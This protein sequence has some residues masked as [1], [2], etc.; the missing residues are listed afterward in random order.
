MAVASVVAPVLDSTVMIEKRSSTADRVAVDPIS[1]QIRVVQP[2]EYQKAAACLA[3]A[4]KEDHVARY[5]IDTPDRAHWSEED[6]FELHKQSMEYLTYAHCLKGLVT[7]VGPDYDAVALWLPPGKNVG[8]VLTILRSGM[9][10][11]RFK[12]SKEG[13]DRFFTEFLPLLEDTKAEVLGDRDQDSWYLNYIGT[14]EASRG[15]GYARKLIEHVTAVV[16][17]SSFTKTHFDADIHR[18]IKLDRHAISRARTP[19]MSK[20]MKG[21]VSPCE[22]RSG[23]HR[24]T[25]RPEWM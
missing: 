2:H 17:W 20:F 14:K 18:P 25:K 9:W 7:T 1:S 10:R 4:F 5:A 11:L 24:P 13:K 12:L 22:S 6:K 16:G 8:D 19:L 3:E 23:S 15:K 21:W